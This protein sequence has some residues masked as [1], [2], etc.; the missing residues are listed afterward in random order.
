M[1]THSSRER[2]G[3]CM[4]EVMSSAIPAQAATLDLKLLHKSIL[5][6][7]SLSLTCGIAIQDLRV[8]G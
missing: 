3:T 2:V 4:K 6:I 1:G 8:Q 5:I 7:P